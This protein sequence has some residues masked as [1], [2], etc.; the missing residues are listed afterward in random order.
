MAASP[1][2]LVGILCNEMGL[3]RGPHGSLLPWGGRPPR[4]VHC[5]PSRRSNGRS[6]EWVAQR[7]RHM[8]L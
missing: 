1:K 6:N 3:T 5:C 7:F 2:M 4:S 8:S